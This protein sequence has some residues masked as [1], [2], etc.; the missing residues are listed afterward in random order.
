MT[1]REQEE[2]LLNRCIAA[3]RGMD[4]AHAQPEANVFNVAAMILV[5]LDHHA[6]NLLQASE[7]YFRH[8]PEEKLNPA[9]VIGRGWIISLPRLRDMLTRQLEGRS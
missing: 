7:H 6:H 2:E 8:H 1:A 5:G 9:E 3:A 4:N